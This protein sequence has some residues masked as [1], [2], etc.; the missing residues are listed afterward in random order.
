MKVKCSTVRNILIII[1]V[2]IIFVGFTFICYKFGHTDESTD[3]IKG[4]II[5]NQFVVVDAKYDLVTNNI[6]YITYDKNTN[7]EYYIT[8]DNST[9]TS[10]CP[11]YNDDGT[12]KIYKE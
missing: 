7:V 8:K 4:R 9:I 1:L 3:D 10:I 11:V 12:I 2:I 6:L 5:Y